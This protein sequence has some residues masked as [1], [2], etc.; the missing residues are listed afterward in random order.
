MNSDMNRPSL[1]TGLAILLALA[2]GGCNDETPPAAPCCRG[3][4]VP[5]VVGS[6]GTGGGGGI[7]GAGGEAGE[8]GRGGAGG[9]RDAC[10][11][12]SDLAALAGLEPNNARQVSASCGTVDCS[13]EL[14]Q[15]QAVFTECV[16][17]CVENK[18]PDLS[19]ECATCYGD[20]AWCAGL[21]CNTSCAN[22][23]CGTGCL[24]CTQGTFD[25]QQCLVRL[26]LCA[27]RESIDC[28]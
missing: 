28:N 16:T 1:L 15:G 4:V 12:A 23:S 19:P 8:G 24:M 20:L 3:E 25:Y 17:G 14:G 13:N 11:N 9:L 2:I 5:P 21:L 6:G 27:G 26:S 10:N 18:V 7:G 22:L